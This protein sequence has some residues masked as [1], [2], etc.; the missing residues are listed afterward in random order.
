PDVR[1]SGNN[2]MDQN[3]NGQN[4]EIPGDQYRAAFTISNVMVFPS[5]NVPVSII[6]TFT[7]VSD[8]IVNQHVTIADLNLQLDIVHP[9]DGALALSL[10]S[11][12]GADIPLVTYPSVT[13]SDFD[14]TIFDDQAATTIAN[15]AP[16]YQGSYR[17]ES[18]LS[19]VNGRDAFG[20]WQLTI[21]DS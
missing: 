12:W 16:P 9:H 18:P 19:L 10:R 17:P 6:P 3:R 8:L 21:S 1:D 4:G 13:G 20:T 7:A 5:A 11:P 14:Q 2:Q 15:G